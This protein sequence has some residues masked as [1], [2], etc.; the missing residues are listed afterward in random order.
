MEENGEE[1]RKTKMVNMRRI[2]SCLVLAMV[3]FA[4]VANA[5]KK[6]DE[7]ILPPFIMQ[8]EYSLPRVLYK[9]DVTLQEVHKVPGIYASKAKEVLGIDP[10]IMSEGSQ[11]SMEGVKISQF[12]EPDPKCRYTFE[13]SPENETLQLEVT[14]DGLLAGMGTK[15]SLTAQFESAQADI[16]KAD[17]KVQQLYEIQNFNMLNYVVDS[18][19]VEVK[20]PKNSV[21]MQFDPNSPYHYDVKTGDNVLSEVLDKIYELREDRNDLLRGDREIDENASLSTILKNYDKLESDYFALFLGSSDTVYHNYTL[22]VTPE[23]IKTGQVI[24]RVS[25]SK[26][27]TDVKDASAMPVILTYNNVQ[28]PTRQAVVPVFHELAY[29]VPATATVTVSYNN[30]ELTRFRSIIP[31]WGVI[32]KFTPTELMRLNMEFYPEYGSLKSVVLS[33]RE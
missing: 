25:E 2:Y 10:E 17:V 30:K 19:F 14:P 22:Y 16:E 4:T 9:V 18:V 13:S 5:Q 26:G 32:Q 6:K 15:S 7:V 1:F 24:F 12:S 20:G 23:N 3:L 33:G 28:M 29:R 27:M 21:T 11:W 8:L 31:Q